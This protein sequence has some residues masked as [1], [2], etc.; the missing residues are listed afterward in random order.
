[1][2]RAVP[3]L[4]DPAQRAAYRRELF[5]VGKGVRRTGAALA[6]LGAGLIVANA[7]W[8]P[9]PNV[10]IYPILLVAFAL[11]AGGIVLRGRYHRRRMRGLI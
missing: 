7:Y 8:R 4:T 2:S 3:D 6:V 5:G 11:M 10:V 9:V 1:L